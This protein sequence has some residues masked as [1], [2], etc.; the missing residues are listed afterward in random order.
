MKRMTLLFIEIRMFQ[1]IGTTIRTDIRGI[2]GLQKYPSSGESGIT[3]KP[4]IIFQT[5]HIIDFIITADTE[6][7]L[8][9]NFVNSSAYGWVFFLN[10]RCNLRNSRIDGR[11]ILF[12]FRIVNY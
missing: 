10:N 1:S 8:A 6:V 5:G 7:M 11:A 3:D 9:N 4:K 12:L 2:S